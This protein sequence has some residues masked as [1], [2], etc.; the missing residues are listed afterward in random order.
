MGAHTELNRLYGLVARWEAGGQQAHERALAH[1]ARA[2]A[3]LRRLQVG[4]APTYGMDGPEREDALE[5]AQRRVAELE[6]LLGQAARAVGEQE[7]DEAGQV[8]EERRAEGLLADVENFEVPSLPAFEAHGHRKR[9]G[10]ILVAEGV[11]S[12]DE[13]QELLTEQGRTPHVRLGTLAV[14]RGFT[15]EALV[16]KILAAQLRLPFVNLAEMTL[17]RATAALLSP[18]LARLHKCVPLRR[19]EDRLT[20]AMTNPL[21]LI[22][23]EDIELAGKCVVGP[24]VAT[25]SGIRGALETLYGSTV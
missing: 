17:D 15:N 16:A 22:A 13:L 3:Q 5:A 11:L 2:E 10:E 8:G 7:S 24:V 23:I 1:L 21:D 9:V 6:E 20:V 25:P 18:H 14:A 12:P 4:A 19:E